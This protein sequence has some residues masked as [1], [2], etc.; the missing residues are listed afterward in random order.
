[1]DFDNDINDKFKEI[2]GGRID[3]SDDD[4]D[5]KI[6]LNGINKSANKYKDD[7]DLADEDDEE[8]DNNEDDDEDDD[9]DDDE[10]EDD[11][12]SME[13]VLASIR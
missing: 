12:N 6:K 13:G 5:F 1:M 11:E 2:I 3:D 4:D 10:D 7:D 9:D 8:D